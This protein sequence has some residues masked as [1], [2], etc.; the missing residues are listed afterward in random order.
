MTAPVIIAIGLGLTA[1][2]AAALR[3]PAGD[4]IE[5][6]GIAALGA[7]IAGAVGA[8]SVRML[9]GRSIGL[10][11]TVI[12]LTSAI[13]VV[14]GAIAAAQKMFISEHDLDALAVVVTS[15]ATAGAAVAAVLARRIER[16][17]G[18]ISDQV[19]DV[20]AGEPLKASAGE[21][22]ELARLSRELNEM[23]IRLNQ[24]RERERA[25]DRSRRELVAWVSHDLRTP[26]SAIRAMA[27]AL[28]DGVVTDPATVGRYHSTIK[29]EAVRL[30]LLV[31]DLFEL[32]RLH[33]GTFQL[34][35]ERV[36][37]S[38][39]VSDSIAAADPIASAKGVRL[40]GSLVASGPE[41]EISPPEISRVLRNLL[42]NAIRH[43]PS[44]GVVQVDL[45]FEPEHV[46]VSVADSCG[47]IPDDDLDRVFDVAFRGEA[48]RT[49]GSGG[50]GLGLAIARG[51][52][53]AHRGEIVVENS[54]KGCRF[55][56]KLPQPVTS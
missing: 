1:L 12:A 5:L 21:T 6:A 27:E 23:S 3:L 54:G 53:E 35:M 13:A 38:D 43:T 42:E 37:I 36:S 40:Q 48:A 41:L 44:E 33:S 15:A 50:A 8:A 4:S 11:A 51:I 31:D 39:L 16:S 52:V 34:Q 26:L 28:E 29:S 2:V 20:Q 56:I 7:G 22:K 17:T 25:V 49:P 9:R 46:C 55:T 24:A 30:A 10:L 47:G 32:S 19:R 45:G 14:I 18:T